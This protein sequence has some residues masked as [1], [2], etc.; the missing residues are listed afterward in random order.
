MIQCLGLTHDLFSEIHMSHDIEILLLLLK[1]YHHL[2]LNHA[3]F[4]TTVRSYLNYPYRQLCPTLAWRRPSAM[5]WLP[6]DTINGASSDHKT[7]LK[8]QTS[9][10][11]ERT[12]PL[13]VVDGVKYIPSQMDPL[14]SA[15]AKAAR[16]DPIRLMIEDA[17]VLL[18]LLRYIPKTL[19]PFFTKNKDAELYIS[20]ANAKVGFL[21]T[22][23][24]LI[25]ILFLVLVIPAFLSLPG[26]IFSA[27]TALFCLACYLITLP[28]Q[29][30]AINFSNMNS[31]TKVLAEQHRNERWVFV[32]GICTG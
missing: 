15:T 7:V 26:G 27:A 2:A 11:L 10:T 25:Q 16:Q 17:V 1:I 19:A 20:L 23:L 5:P 8:V 32:N 30:P 29:G 31:Y 12:P 6:D 4:P 3:L 22:L 24:A 18:R 14:A 21:Q 9:P 28:M 13:A